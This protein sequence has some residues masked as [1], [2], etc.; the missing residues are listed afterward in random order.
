MEEKLERWKAILSESLESKLSQRQFCKERGIN[1]STLN[2][3]KRRINQMTVPVFSGTRLVRVPVQIPPRTSEI[4][5]EVDGRYR[6][7]V[8][9]GASTESL[10]RVLEAFR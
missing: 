6:L 10:R 9:E 5:I 8:P 2:Y 1:V 7:T 3:W 4:V